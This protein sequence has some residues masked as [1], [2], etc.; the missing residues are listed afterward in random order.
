M[1]F[2][3][4]AVLCGANICSLSDHAEARALSDGKSKFL[5]H[6]FFGLVLRKVEL[7]EASVTLGEPLSFARYFLN[8][9]ILLASHTLQRAESVKRDLRA[10]GYELQQESQVGLRVSFDYF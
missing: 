5:F 1:K 4:Q 7:V 2:V 3:S 6:N 10:S 9:E 8:I